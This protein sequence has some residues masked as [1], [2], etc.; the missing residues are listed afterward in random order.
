MKSSN[1]ILQE[2]CKGNSFQDHETE[3]KAS[4][5]WLGSPQGGLGLNEKCLIVDVGCGIGKEE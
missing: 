4:M 5:P 2:G 3:K 1:L